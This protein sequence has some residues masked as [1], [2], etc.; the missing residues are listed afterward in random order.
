MTRLHWNADLIVWPEAAVPELEAL[1]S[2]YLTG[3]DSAATFNN[4]ALITGIV[5][6]QYDT[7]NIFNTLIV[8]GK[9]ELEDSI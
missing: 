4:T 9:K 6:Y 3:L 1:A 8:L 2:E 7:R 5:D